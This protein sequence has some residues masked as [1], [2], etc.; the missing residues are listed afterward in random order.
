[1][2]AA[3]DALAGAFIVKGFEQLVAEADDIFVGTVTAVPARR[4][5]GGAIVTDVN[6]S[7]LQVMKGAPDR[8]ALSLQMLGGT[9]DGET[10]RLSGVP[11]FAPGVR[12]LVFSKGNGRLILPLVGGTSGLFRVARDPTTGE[13]LVLDAEGR[14]VAGLRI[15]LGTFREAISDE[16]KR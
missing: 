13:E 6:F 7:A 16:L 8:G 14:P 4:L 12:Y 1:M 5:P 10:E 11:Q 9:L 15:T 2:F 3:K